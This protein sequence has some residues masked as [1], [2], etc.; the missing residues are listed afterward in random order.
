MVQ[1]L[2]CV[3]GVDGEERG[4]GRV[5][6]RLEVTRRR[7]PIHA[8]VDDSVVALCPRRE[9]GLDR[10][11]VVGI[12]AETRFLRQFPRSGYRQRFVVFGVATGQRP[13]SLGGWLAAFDAADVVAVHDCHRSPRDG[14]APEHALAVGAVRTLPA[15]DL[16]FFHSGATERAVARID[17]DHGWWFAG[18]RKTVRTYCST[19]SMAAR[20]TA[21]SS[22]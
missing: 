12:D 1:A 2:P 22:V 19:A 4:V 7:R 21:A 5:V 3:V 15:V 8:E 17:G 11:E 9:P 20:Q 14:R 13:R 10:F 18:P 16:A 6:A